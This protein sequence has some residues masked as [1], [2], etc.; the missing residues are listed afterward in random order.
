M[1]D[2][3]FTLDDVRQS[4]VALEITGDEGFR[5]RRPE[6]DEPDQPRPHRA[7]GR[8]PFASIMRIRMASRCS[9][10]RCS[11]RS[12]IAA[13]RDKASPT[14]VVMWS[15]CPRRSCGV[16]ENKVTTCDQAPTWSHGIAD[17]MRNLARRGLLILERLTMDTKQLI[18]LHRRAMGRGRRCLRQPQSFR[19]ARHR[20]QGAGRR[21][22]HGEC[23]RGR[24]Q[25]RFP[26]WADASPKCARTCS[27]RSAR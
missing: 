18:P 14:K 3:K 20:R 11:R 15:G 13:R 10:A 4:V 17:L 2:G 21:Q 8:R 1:F 25:G 26:A 19:H 23:R 5:A 16:L 9:S 6:L 22:R 27:T 24:G 12:S 7:R